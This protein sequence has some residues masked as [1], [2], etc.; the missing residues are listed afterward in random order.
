MNIIS[1]KNM[2]HLLKIYYFHSRFKFKKNAI[3]N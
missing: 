1:Q 2:L 3:V